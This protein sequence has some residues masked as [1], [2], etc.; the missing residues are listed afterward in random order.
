M[1]VNPFRL[2]LT[3]ESVTLTLGSVDVNPFRLT[4]TLE[5]VTLVLESVYV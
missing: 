4:L 3:L 2:T 1:Y 5:S